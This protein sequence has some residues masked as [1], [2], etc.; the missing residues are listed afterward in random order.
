VFALGVAEGASAV[1]VVLQEGLE[2][3]SFNVTLLGLGAHFE[4]L[5][6]SPQE[7]EVALSPLWGGLNSSAD[8][9]KIKF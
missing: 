7:L 5:L 1:N 4:K 6:S 2:L 3:S 8:A 9:G